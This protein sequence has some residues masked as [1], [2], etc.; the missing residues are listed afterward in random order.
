M[1]L[2]VCF[3]LRNSND[4]V[5]FTCFNFKKSFKIILDQKGIHVVHLKCFH[6]V[7]SYKNMKT[8]KTLMKYTKMVIFEGSFT[9][10]VTHIYQ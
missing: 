6:T 1:P 8:V 7:D 5:R 9:V 2:N 10:K 3:E 4:L